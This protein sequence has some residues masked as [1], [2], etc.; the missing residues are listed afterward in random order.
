MDKRDK[1]R[2]WVKALRSGEFEQSRESLKVTKQDAEDDKKF[3]AKYPDIEGEAR[4]PGYCCLGVLKATCPTDFKYTQWDSGL[5]KP[6]EAEA[7]FGEDHQLIQ[8]RLS[9]LNDNGVPFEIIAGTLKYG[10]RL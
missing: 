1:L 4:T 3:Y 5:L 10:Y 8:D 7:F 6:E 9:D 2:K